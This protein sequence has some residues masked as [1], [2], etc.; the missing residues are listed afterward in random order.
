VNFTEVEAPSTVQAAEDEEEEPDYDES[1][2]DLN[3]EQ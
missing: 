3:D 2:E 1:G